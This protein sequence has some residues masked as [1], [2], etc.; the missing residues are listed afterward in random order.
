MELSKTASAFGLHSYGK[1][2]PDGK[3]F[4]LFNASASALLNELGI[5][6]SYIGIEG[7]G[8]SGDYK[9][10]GGSAHEKLIKSGFGGISVLSIVAN[11]EGSDEPSYDGYATLSFSFVDSTQEALLCFV[12]NELFVP[13]ASDAYDDAWKAFLGLNAW[14]FGYGFREEAEKQPEF[15]ILGL[16]NGHLTEAEQSALDAWY[17][18]LPDQRLDRLRGIYAY[19]FVSMRQLDKDVFDGVTLRQFIEQDQLGEIRQ[20]TDYGLHLWK[21]D[22]GRAVRVRR[23]MEVARALISK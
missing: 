10:Y 18:A 19:N 12:V 11:P 3:A 2:S 22:E 16:D 14:D 15:H 8:Y 7:E 21:L 20:L 23:Q 4:E 5:T 17:G 9:K 13:F 6:P 1:P